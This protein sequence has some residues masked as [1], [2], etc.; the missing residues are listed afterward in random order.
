MRLISEYNKHDRTDGASSGRAVAANR[1]RRNAAALSLRPSPALT[2]AK[3]RKRCRSPAPT[4]GQA[5]G[6]ARDWNAARRGAMK[7]A[8]TRSNCSIAWEADGNNNNGA[9]ATN[10]VPS[11]DM[12]AQMAQ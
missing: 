9:A 7:I 1:E 2:E 8:A 5:A 12:V 11:N 4:G 10:E 3:K 6:G